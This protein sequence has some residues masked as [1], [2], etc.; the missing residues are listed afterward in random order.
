M[1][2]KLTPA[3]HEAIAHHGPILKIIAGAGSGKTEVLAQR[4]VRLLTEGVEPASFVAF[5]FTEKAE[6]VPQGKD[7]ATRKRAF[8]GR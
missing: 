5:T 6:G 3:Q 1:P 4:A 8:C 7:R 2:K